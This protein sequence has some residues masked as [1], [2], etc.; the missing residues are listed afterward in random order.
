MR[1]RS[2]ILNDYLFGELPDEQRAELLREIEADPQLS[3]ELAELSPLVAT[4]EDL[5]AE[6]W[7]HVEAPPL[8]LNVGSPEPE[9]RSRLKDFFGGSFSL[10][11]ALAFAAVLAIFA[12]GLGVGLLTGADNSTTSFG[13]VATQTN[14]SPVGEL[15][16]A[17]TGQAAVKQGGQVIRLKISGLAVNSDNDFYEAWLMDPKDGFI[18]LGT[19]RVGEDGSTTLDLPVAVSTSRFPVVDISLQPTNGKPTHSGVSVL[20]G[21]LN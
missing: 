13:P 17:A 3:A 11:P 9:H 19:F 20:R 4:L 14:L 7:D 15:D 5:P 10:R 6:A 8:R 16:P 12:M 18:S 2:E 1:D 21:T